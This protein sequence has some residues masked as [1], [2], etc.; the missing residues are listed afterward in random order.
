[1]EQAVIEAGRVLARQGHL[2]IAITHP[3]NTAGAFASG[4]VERDRPFVID[5]SWFERRHLVREAEQDGFTMTFELEHR[6]LQTYT[7]VLVNAGFVVERIGELGEPDAGV[8]WS[9]IP[10]FLHIRAVQM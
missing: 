8:K 4:P 1:V 5:G 6:P 10:L 2:V 7:D 9:R 3:L